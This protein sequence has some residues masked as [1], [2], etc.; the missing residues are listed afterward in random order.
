MRC[1]R[2][3]RGTGAA[4]A[5]P[6]SADRRRLR[7]DLGDLVQPAVAAGEAHAGHARAAARDDEPLRL[8]GAFVRPELV[9]RNGGGATAD[10]APVYPASEE[11]SAAKV[12]ELVAEALALRARRPGRPADLGQGRARAAAEG[13]CARRAPR[14]ALAR[15][16]GGGATAARVRRAARPP[17]RARPAERRAGGGGRRRAAGAGRAGR[18]LP[19]RAS[20]HAHGTSGRRRSPSSMPISP[21]RPRCSGCSRATSAP[22]RPSSRSTRS[23]ARSR[24]AVRAR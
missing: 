6:D 21:A 12:R 16:G 5:D 17:A 20:V 13:R 9:D 8:P 10:F 24:P 22:A 14:A 4:A 7:A 2:P 15:R 11:I 19:R 1:S 23:C 3:R 18:A